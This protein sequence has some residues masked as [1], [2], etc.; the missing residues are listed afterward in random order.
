M[1]Y[2]VSIATLATILG[3]TT[4]RIQDARLNGTWRS[5]REATVAAAFEQWPGW[6]NASPEKL[7]SFR[8]VFGHMIVTHSNGISRIRW[9]GDESTLRYRIRDRGED[10]VVIRSKGSI[11][12]DGRD[13]RI[14]FVE[15]N[16]AYWVD[17]GPLGHGLQE[18]FDRVD[19]EQGAAPNAGP[20]TPIDD[21]DARE[22][23]AIG[24][25]WRSAK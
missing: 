12:D 7:E 17:L 20:A 8:N 5:N 11:I 2:F 16:T 15:N 23:A 19:T 4:N 21:S 10:Y 24:E 25:L 1:R 13:I 22:G 3:C 18:R 9:N 6:T 14:R